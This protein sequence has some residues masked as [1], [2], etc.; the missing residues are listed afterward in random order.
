MDNMEW[1]EQKGGPAN[2]SHEGA[3]N[4]AMSGFS[5]DD[6]LSDEQKGALRAQARVRLERWPRLLEEAWAGHAT[7]LAL[8]RLCAPGHAASTALRTTGFLSRARQHSSRG[9]SYG[10]KRVTTQ[11]KSDIWPVLPRWVEHR[12]AFCK[13]SPNEPKPT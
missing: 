8:S 5:K 1:V 13:R 11:F 3:L 6:H 12:T 7:S 9:S 4:K 2:N 10:R